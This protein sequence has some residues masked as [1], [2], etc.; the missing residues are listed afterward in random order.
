MLEITVREEEM[1]V[2]E[3]FSGNALDYLQSIYRDP[4]QEQYTRMRA[5]A[6]AIAYESPKLVATAVIDGK[7][8][9]TILERRIAH[10]RRIE[11]A[12]IEEPKAIVEIK[13]HLPTVP[14]RR[15][16]RI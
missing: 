14:D 9:A 3:P 10:M 7:D 8:F 13:P 1:E 16:R 15:F 12:K 6:M 4:A 5:A 2:V 11:A